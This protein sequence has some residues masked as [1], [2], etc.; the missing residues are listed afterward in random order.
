MALTCK[1]ICRYRL[2]LVQTRLMRTWYESTISMLE[3]SLTL[4][5]FSL[6]VPWP[7]FSPITAQNKIITMR[8]HLILST[9]KIEIL[10]RLTNNGCTNCLR[11][12]KK[13]KTAVSLP[14]KSLN[15]TVLYCTYT[16]LKTYVKLKTAYV[17]R[18]LKYF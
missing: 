11:P 3:N 4:Y 17:P 16:T 10:I 13:N 15:Q 12:W 8:N 14:R 2:I 6:E 18:A 7:G 5:Y 9:R 1:A